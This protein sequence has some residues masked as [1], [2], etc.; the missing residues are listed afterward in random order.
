MP[1]GSL[2]PAGIWAFE[3]GLTACQ[4]MRGCHLSENGD[5][6]WTCNHSTAAQG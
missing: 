1:E 4:A 6:V 5:T 2:Q 3:A